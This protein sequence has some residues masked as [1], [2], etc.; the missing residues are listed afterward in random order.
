MLLKNA[1]GVLPLSN[2]ASILVVGDAAHLQPY[3]CG[4]GSGGL[5]PPYVVDPLAG[6]TA[7]AGPGTSVTYQPGLPFFQNITTWFSPSRGD[8]FLDFACDEC[9]GLYT[10]VRAEGYASAA[11]CPTL[12]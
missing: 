7:R 12:A 1:P 10:A 6:I 11:P 8:H 4:D 5:I 2:P 9:Y 3:C